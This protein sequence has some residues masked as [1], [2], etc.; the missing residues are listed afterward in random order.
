[1]SRILWSGT[2]V[3]VIG[4]TTVGLLAAF[5]YTGL[6]LATFG[7]T[8]AVTVGLVLRATSSGAGQQV[9]TASQGATARSLDTDR[10][11]GTTTGTVTGSPTVPATVGA[12]A[13]VLHLKGRGW[14]DPE[15]SLAHDLEAEVRPIS[16]GVSTSPLAATEIRRG[17]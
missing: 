6:A 10:A 4:G 7:L 5:W 1:M 3:A 15:P 8:A 11:T 17:A 14:S 2:G 13:S 16:P 12:L 9:V